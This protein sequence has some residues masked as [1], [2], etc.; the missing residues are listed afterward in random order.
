MATETK[1]EQTP[2]RFQ[3]VGGDLCLDFCNT[4][5]GNRSGI[6]KEFLHTYN[7]LAHWAEQAGLASHGAAEALR[8]KALLVPVDAAAALGRAKELREAIYRIFL[9]LAHDRSPAEHDLAILNG[10]LARGL[11]RMRVGRHGKEFSWHWRGDPEQLDHVLAPVA[12]SAA[13]LLVSGRGRGH[14]NACA[15]HNC[16]WLFVDTTKNHSR[17]WCDMRD[18]GNRAKVRAHRQR[19]KKAGEK[20]PE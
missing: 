4:V 19:L 7:E 3:F 5:G 13:D 12:R 20:P 1:S 16:G 18:C 17:R 8:Q 9:A 15:A 14:V 11:N 2:F 10:E 6:P